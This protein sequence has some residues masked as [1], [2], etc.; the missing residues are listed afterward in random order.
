MDVKHIKRYSVL[1][2]I[3]E[4]Q[5]KTTVRCHYMLSKVAKMKKTGRSKYLQ[6][7]RT[8]GTFIQCR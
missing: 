8:T 4:M 1:L 2:D 3:K 5:M 6:G 7:C